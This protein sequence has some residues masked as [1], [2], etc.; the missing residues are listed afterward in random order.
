MTR[1]GVISVKAVN[2]YRRRDVIAYLGLRYYLESEA[3]RKDLWARDVATRLERYGAGGGYLC[4][5]HFKELDERGG[6]AHRDIYVPRPNEALAEVA[7][8]DACA[9]AG[10]KFHASHNVYSYMLSSHDDRQGVFCNYIGGLRRR[11]DAISLACSSDPRALVSFRDLKKFYPSI[12]ID[13]AH[14]VWKGACAESTLDSNYVALGHALLERHGEASGGHLLTGP[15]FSHLIGNLVLRRID[16]LTEGGGASYFRYVDDIT[17]VRAATEVDE[18]LKRIEGSLEALG[19]H[20]H[21]AGSPKS[22][23]VEGARWMHSRYDFEEPKEEES[24]MTLVGD[25]KH[26]LLWSPHDTQDLEERLE[27]EGMRLPMRDYSGAIAEASY[28]T[29]AIYRLSWQWRKRRGRSVTPTTILAQAKSLRRKYTSD[30]EDLSAKLRDSDN[31]DTKRYASMARYRLGRLA[32]LA[33]PADLLE[34]ANSTSTQPQLAFHSEVARAVATQDV[35]RLLS[36]GTN[37]AQAAAQPLRAVTSRV[38]IGRAPKTE[39]EFQSL[40]VLALNGILPTDD[41]DLADRSELSQFSLQGG[42]L[43]LMQ[44]E[45]KFIA[46]V[47]SL[48]GI[49]E[50]RHAAT[51]DTAFDFDEELAL[52]AI[53]QASTSM[54]I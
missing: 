44:S 23:D 30:L 28:L 9:R 51:I 10:G 11:H 21:A 13:L 8:I 33:S 6:V 31:F 5:K 48:H 25:V 39:A 18:A 27:G 24:W 35:S 42:S 38:D 20:V 45:S 54:Y 16:D 3:S 41:A 26:V 50:A 52:D 1:P 29:R 40:A 32:Y 2:Q 49:G 12:R 36:L 22:L 14:A 37:A 43:R 46:E 17:L 7:L 34:A 53:D 4:L 15:L 19:L 47:A